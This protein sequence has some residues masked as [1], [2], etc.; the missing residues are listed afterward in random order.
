[1]YGK[2]LDAEEFAV[3]ELR[4]LITE[5]NSTHIEIESEIDVLLKDLTREQ[6]QRIDLAYEPVEGIKTVAINNELAQ[7]RLQYILDA[8][9]QATADDVTPD[10]IDIIYGGGAKVSNIKDMAEAGYSGAFIGRA[11]A[12][13]VADAGQDSTA[14]LAETAAQTGK[15]LTMIFN[16]KSREARP[17]PSEYLEGYGQKSVN[18]DSG[19]KV[20]HAVSLLDYRGWT[21][22][23]EGYETDQLFTDAS[24]DELKVGVA[25]EAGVGIAEREPGEFTAHNPSEFFKLPRL[26]PIDCSKAFNI[27]AIIKASCGLSS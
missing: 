19:V 7:Y 22:A 10:D 16:A 24:K 1:M 26:I 27:F 3:A 5:E 15:K 13:P 17:L 11:S 4:R 6:M 9:V 14:N 18:F 25:V 8:I 12:K 20:I 23:M 2:S 21:Q